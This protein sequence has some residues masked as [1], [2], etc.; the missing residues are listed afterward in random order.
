MG[1]FTK[2][3]ECGKEFYK[4]SGKWVYGNC[5]SY[6][7]YDHFKLRSEKKQL[8]PDKY[9]EYVDRCESAMKSQG[10]TVLE[11]I[12]KENTTEFSNNFDGSDSCNKS[13]NKTFNSF[14]SS[15]YYKR[16]KGI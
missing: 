11:P 12:T 2:C 15:N 1:E 16:K 4:S 7:C 9:F 8:D 3:P 13:C 14:Y 10:K 5:C 6:T